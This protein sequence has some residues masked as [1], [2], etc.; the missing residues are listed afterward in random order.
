MGEAVHHF[1]DERCCGVCDIGLGRK[2]LRFGDQA[3]TAGRFGNFIAGLYLSDILPSTGKPD[4]CISD[5]CNFLFAIPVF[6]CMDHVEKKVVLE[7]VNDQSRLK[8]DAVTLIHGITCN[9]CS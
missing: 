9:P 7:S 6:N 1:W 2:A 4:Q 3:E 5:L 8:S